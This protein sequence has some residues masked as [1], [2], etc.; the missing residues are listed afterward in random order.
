MKKQNDV[1]LGTTGPRRLADASSRA[2]NARGRS[3]SVGR[4]FAILSALLM[5]FAID[6]CSSSASATSPANAA[7][8]PVED[9][10]V[11]TTDG[12]DSDGA[13]T[14]GVVPPSPASVAFWDDDIHA[15]S[16]RGAV[17]LGRAA[18][19]SAVKDYV[20]YW[21]TD[22][23]NKSSLIATIAKDDV[24]SPFQLT[25]AVPASATHILAFARS[26]AGDLST[27]IAVG[28]VDN[29]LT[30]A[31][32]SAGQGK[33]SGFWPQ[34]LIDPSGKLL[35]V[36]N[37][38]SKVPN[39]FRCDLAGGA[40]TYASIST[41]ETFYITGAPKPLI[42]TASG[43]LVIIGDAPSGP[44]VRCALD[45]T[46]CT[47]GTF[48]AD[49]TAS[50]ATLNPSPALDVA[51]GKLLI[52]TSNYANGKRVSLFRCNLDGTGCVHTDASA[53]A[54]TGDNTGNTPSAVIDPTG[55]KLLIVTSNCSFG[56]ESGKLWLFR[57]DLDG[58]K[59]TASDISAT[60][61]AYSGYRPIA[62]T[63]AKNGKLVALAANGGDPND[64]PAYGTV[65]SRCALD[66][67]NCTRRSFSSRSLAA[68]SINA[69]N[70]RLFVV[71]TDHDSKPWLSSCDLDGTNCI[72]S[73]ISAGLTNIGWQP[74]AVFDEASRTLF[75]VTSY[76]DNG[77][78]P[79]LLRFGP[80]Q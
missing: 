65:M 55:S 3:E 51:N 11:S 7:T 19:E 80:A 35:V 16:V 8:P 34:P 58:T 54:G 13:A 69:T 26:A 12:G 2:T 46:N 18:D 64:A 57:C 21:G 32:I 63:D 67:T 28:P 53:L 62:L 6:G 45:G 41:S 10:A 71:T 52:A 68:A 79:S 49:Q 5:P 15:G 74:G 43:K 9:P 22:S 38:D 24:A 73:D 48:R 40:C 4:A 36:T 59:C 17:R 25:G 76:I 14:T 44:L 60:S 37:P 50:N 75:V 30:H 66:G 27:P 31:D 72:E 1:T 61:S 20:L 47:L 78:R 29:V 56:I 23:A 70:D 42:D 77:Y 33:D 39:L